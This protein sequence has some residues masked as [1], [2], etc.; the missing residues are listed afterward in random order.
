MTGGFSYFNLSGVDYVAWLWKKSAAAGFDIVTW[1]GNESDPMNAQPRTVDYSL[2]NSP[3]EMI[4]AKDFLGSTNRWVYH[5][6][7]LLN[8][9]YEEGDLDGASGGSTTGIWGDTAPGNTSFTVKDDSMSGYS[10]NTPPSLTDQD[11]YVAYCFRSIDGHS[12][13]GIRSGTGSDSFLHLGFKPRFLLYKNISAGG[14]NWHIFDSERPGYNAI[15]GTSNDGY[16][17]YPDD[18]TAESGNHELDFLSNGI[19]FRS[20]QDWINNSTDTYIFY[21]AGNPFKHASAR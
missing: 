2:G 3:A 16:A 20:T 15:K 8:K 12:K 17:L 1:E 10:L 21:A 7:I 18:T 11:N 9:D 19:M 5:T 14:T 6:A 4:I 13:C